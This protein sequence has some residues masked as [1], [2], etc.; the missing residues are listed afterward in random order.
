MGEV[1]RAKDTRLDRT[2]AIKVLP[3]G[4]AADPERRARF[5]REA[6]AASALN[7]PHICTLHD[8]GHQD[9]VDY[10]VLEHLEGE[11]LADRLASGPLPLD[12]VLRYGIEIAEGL[13]AAHRAGI[14]HRDLK[15]GNVML[16]K[17]GAKLLD[18]GLAKRAGAERGE[19]LSVMQTATQA[20]PLTSAGTVMG[21]I[22]YMSPEQLE[23]K[24]ADAR[25]D[26]WALGTLLYEMATGK[27]AFSGV[28]QA[29]IAAAILKE[30]P[31]PMR[32]LQPVAPPALDRLVRACL[33]KDPDERMQS[34][35]D[36]GRELEWMRDGSETPAISSGAP[37]RGKWIAW[38]AAALLLGALT[39]AWAGR[40]WLPKGAAG[41]REPSGPVTHTVIDL[42]ANAP[43][44]LGSHIPSEGFESPVL[45]LSPDGR[46]LAY[47]GQ[48]GSE[49][50]LY[51]R[52]MS[53]SGVRPIPGTEGAI[54]AFFSPDSQWLGFL[55]DDK[56]KKVSLHGGSPLPLADARSPVL[57]WWT[58]NKGIYFTQTETTRL[59]R[60]SEDGREV[61]DVLESPDGGLTD[62]LPDGSAAIADDRSNGGISRDFW[63]IVLLSPKSK[64]KKL[65][66][67]S[68]YGGRYVPSGYL[69]FARAGALLAVRFNIS[70]L[71][72][73]GEEFPVASDVSM[74][75]LFGQVHATV[76][77]NGLLAY[78]PGGERALGKLAWVDRT[79]NVQFLDVPA[80]VYGVL[81][82]SPDGKR[83][84]VHVAGVKDYVWIYDLE[85]REG[86]QL[87][88]TEH[89]GWP[90]WSPDNLTI[91]LTSLIK[92]GS[93]ILT[94]RVDEG[95]AT[96]EVLRS[97]SGDQHVE[98]T[99]WLPGGGALALSRFPS[100]I[101]FVTLEG[102]SVGFE[103]KGHDEWGPEFS[104][105]GRW[106]AY[107]SSETGRSEIWIRSYP[108]G[109]TSH[110]VS[111]DGGIEP[112]WC[113]CGELFFRNG[114][115][116]LSARIIS[117]QPELRWDPPRPAFQADFIDTPGR[118]Y[119]VSPDGQ[120]LI[121]VKRAAA[122]IPTKV[123][124]V[125]NWYEPQRPSR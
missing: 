28:S 109:K 19:S 90:V 31:Q 79:G 83:L 123:H 81:D 72:T 52:S 86:R 80:R 92:G 68:G 60:V 36:V 102:K 73:E 16:T 110:Q 14:L 3:E 75:S 59:S 122:E 1:W 38:V 21:T 67:R 85:R 44:A 27:R 26:I 87:A 124:L 62:V 11:T 97:G 51:L 10:I 77:S 7:H 43:L 63:D 5:E 57:A 42:P 66:V 22:Q 47:V 23:G 91:A 9:G 45:A 103:S 4:F 82:L 24:E 93:T 70:T 2:V 48:S 76:S 33:A 118:S 107:D 106:A 46:Q 53:G 115:Q 120:R 56:V 17:T 89:N 108:D 25:S 35:R 39:G 13:A 41:S 55:T 84:A 88:A 98:V 54:Y 29:S 114:S 94:R 64:E 34:A 8:I 125:T 18:F 65:L 119:D 40:R 61:A 15:P 96:K 20:K 100:G 111:V 6:R 113:P 32:E 78:V 116:W 99:S 117:S 95:A 30:E 37:S 58:R 71:E 112:V 49:T 105:D 101:G 74:E 121:V 12:G 50:M 104:P 69:V